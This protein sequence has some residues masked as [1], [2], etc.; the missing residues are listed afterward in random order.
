MLE[1]KGNRAKVAAAVAGCIAV[2]FG[3]IVL[4][5]YL[6]ARREMKQAELAEARQDAWAAVLHYRLAISAYIPFARYPDRAAERLVA[7]AQ[8]AEKAGD[9]LLALEAYRAIRSG[10]LSARSIYVPKKRWIKKAE[11]EI[12]RLLIK[13]GEPQRIYGAKSKWELERLVRAEMNRYRQPNG[14][15]SL[16]AIAALFGWASF[17]GLGVYQLAKGDYKKALVRIAAFVA[18]YILW[19]ICLIAA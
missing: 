6:D 14:L 4:R 9:T 2:F 18:L 3:L 15:L 17:A 13:R 10:F 11:D 8:R 12:V 19:A 7:I 16:F 5:V 1:M